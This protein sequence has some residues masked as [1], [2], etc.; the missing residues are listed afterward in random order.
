MM[1]GNNEREKIVAIIPARGGSNS[2]PK[3][4]IKILGDKPLIAYPIESARSIEDI[5]RVIVSTDSEEIAK[6]ARKY[7][8]ETPIIRPTKLAEDETPT[9]PVLQ[10]VV[11]Y[12]EETENYK[13]DFIILLYPTAPFLK[14]ERIKEAI[15]LLKTKKHHSV[16]GVVEDRGRY[17]VYDKK[18]EKYIILYP[19]K[20]VNR[21]YFRP[22][23]KENGAIYFSDYETIMVKNKIIDEDNVGFIIMDYDEVID[24]DTPFDWENAKERLKKNENWK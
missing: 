24:L 21:Q 13:A 9:L 5:D 1:E 14:K 18:E 4:N 2:I 12:L 20:R 11:K 10:H 16:I 22:L 3:K 15:N 23:Y 6:V 17:W 19:Q 7:G 8:A